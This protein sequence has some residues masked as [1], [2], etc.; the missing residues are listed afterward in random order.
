MPALRRRRPALNLLES[1]P[2]AVYLRWIWWRALLHRGWWL[3][4]SVYLVVDAR[5]SGAQL[6]LIGVAQALTG[7]TCE[8]PAGAIADT[9]GRKRSLVASHALMGTA[10][11]ATGLVTDFPALVATQMLWGV[12]WN[13]ASGADVAWITDELDDPTRITSVLVRSGRAQLT[14]AAVGLAGVGAL[15][16]LTDRGAA[17]V[18]AGVAMLCLGGFVIL[19]SPNAGSSA[20]ARAECPHRGLRSSMDRRRCGATPPS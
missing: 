7:I 13:L 3:V 9:V 17:M 15:A 12:S 19:R 8:V 11:L 14:G 18:T 1:D 20:P 5:L 2:A 10:M 16:A 4:T 6:V